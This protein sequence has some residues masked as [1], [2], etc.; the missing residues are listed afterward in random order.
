MVSNLGGMVGAGT[1]LYRTATNNDNGFTIPQNTGIDD[2]SSKLRASEGGFDGRLEHEPLHSSHEN[3]HPRSCGIGRAR[4]HHIIPYSLQR[5]FAFASDAT[6]KALSY[7]RPF[8]SLG[9]FSHPTCKLM[10][11]PQE[12]E[13]SRCT[14]DSIPLVTRSSPHAIESSSSNRVIRVLLVSVLILDHTLGI[15]PRAIDA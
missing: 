3:C 2:H 15:E 7:V 12:G 6:R 1:R 14:A 11:V 9:D 8:L 5:S 13:V 10:P 4:I